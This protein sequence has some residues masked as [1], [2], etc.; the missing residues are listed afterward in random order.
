MKETKKLSFSDKETIINA[1]AEYRDKQRKT[2]EQMQKQGSCIKA[3]Q[4]REQEKKAT[5]LLF[6]FCRAL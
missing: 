6:M 5:Q 2:A 3:E 1:L 4:A